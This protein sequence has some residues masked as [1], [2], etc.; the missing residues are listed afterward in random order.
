[1]P[2]RTIRGIGGFVYPFDVSDPAHPKLLPPQQ[3][4]GDGRPHSLTLNSSSFLPG[5]PEG[6]LAFVG[7][8]VQFPYATGGDGLVV[9]DVSD[10]QIRLP[11]PQ[12]RI[13]STLFSPLGG[14]ESMIQ[15][16]IKGHPYI[17]TTDEA[18]GAGGGRTV[19]PARVPGG[20][21]FRVSADR[22]H[23]R[24]DEPQD[25]LQAQAGSERPGELRGAVR[26]DAAGCPG[27][28]AG[29]QF[30]G[31]FGDDQLQ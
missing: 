23:R 6:T 10:Y 29:D 5:V 30:A 7:Q 4:L 1:M 9:E 17:V 2:A 14:A 15:V 13:I 3:Y 12:I 11:N 8:N 20:V 24:P 22:R 28:G 31:Q 18:G 21:S 16:K 27:N 25:R 26:R 19:G